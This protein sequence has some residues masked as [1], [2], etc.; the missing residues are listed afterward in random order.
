MD[1]DIQRPTVA[2][3]VVRREDHGRAIGAEQNHLAAEQR[4]GGKRKWQGGF[5]GNQF[6]EPFLLPG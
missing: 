1:Q 2:D 4:A 6:A 3:D 5:I